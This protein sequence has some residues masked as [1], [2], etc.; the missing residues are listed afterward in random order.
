MG[1]PAPGPFCRKSFPPTRGRLPGV[2]RTRA[3]ARLSGLM[4]CANCAYCVRWGRA[5]ARSEDMQQGR[6]FGERRRQQHI[7]D[8]VNLTI[9]PYSEQVKSW[10]SEGRH[11][12]S[13]FDDD[14]V[15]VY[16]AYRPSTGRYAA[17]N[18]YFGTGFSLNRM[19]WIKPNFLWM[20]F[21]SGCS[22]PLPVPTWELLV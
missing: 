2:K 17:E 20:M 21:R 5:W 3:L 11:I 14:S 19:S 13:Q 9:A 22:I 15:V 6:R 18:G 4:K 7:D 10:P 1:T 12:L 8:T 16:Q